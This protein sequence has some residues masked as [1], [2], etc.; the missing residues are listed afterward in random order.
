MENENFS[1]GEDNS[2]PTIQPKYS[3]ASSHQQLL[4]QDPADNTVV[5][6]DL[7]AD[8]AVA[9]AAAVTAAGPK[10]SNGHSFAENLVVAAGG[11]AGTGADAARLDSLSN[12]GG[13]Y[14][15]RS[16]VRSTYSADSPSPG[17]SSPS[18]SPERESGPS[19]TSEFYREG[20]E[21]RPINTVSVIIIDFFCNNIRILVKN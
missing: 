18:I 20:G 15:E 16:G 3:G 5:V 2:N 1:L 14:S 17:R 13:C 21:P 19:P 10:L 6:A 9:E 4:E 12:D 11:G 8:D 7:A